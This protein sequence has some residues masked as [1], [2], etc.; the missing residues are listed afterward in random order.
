MN[1]FMLTRSIRR[2]S[3]W[4]VTMRLWSWVLRV[5]LTLPSDISRS[6]DNVFNAMVASSVLANGIVSVVE[7]G[8]SIV[9][10]ISKESSNGR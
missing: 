9:A 5:R 1:P 4:N 7:C 10:I 6:T 2:V 3:A 8:S